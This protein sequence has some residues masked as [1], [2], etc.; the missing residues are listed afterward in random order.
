[1]QAIARETNLSETTFVLPSQNPEQ[2]RTEGVRVRIFTTQ[3]ELPFAGHPTLGTATWLRL[4]HAP[5]LRAETVI[6]APERRSR[7]G[8][9]PSGVARQQGGRLRLHAATRPNVPRRVQPG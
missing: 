3:E 5:V 6:A 4:H 1:M 7:A 2:D 9:L 8:T